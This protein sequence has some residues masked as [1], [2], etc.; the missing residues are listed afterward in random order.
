[1]QIGEGESLKKKSPD[2]KLYCEH[3]KIV[4]RISACPSSHVEAWPVLQ[5]FQKKSQIPASQQ[6]TKT[7]DVTLPSFAS[8]VRSWTDWRTL[9]RRN[10]RHCVPFYMM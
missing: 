3:G 6:S 5:L 8:W 4:V 7:S 9:L 1:M 2:E 10:T